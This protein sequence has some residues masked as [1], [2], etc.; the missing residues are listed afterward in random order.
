MKHIS[1]QTVGR[2]RKR[3]KKRG[4]IIRKGV[5]NIGPPVSNESLASFVC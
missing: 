3:G 1:N 5:L 2:K 4:K